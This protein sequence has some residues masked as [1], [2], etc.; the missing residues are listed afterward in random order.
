MNIWKNLKGVHWTAIA[1]TVLAYALHALA[2]DPSLAPES[3][4]LETVATLLGSSGLVTALSS[5]SVTS[6]GASVGALAFV[7]TLAF[8]ASACTPAQT[9]S[10]QKV[11][12]IV[13]GDLEK[14]DTL[15]QIE[16]DVATDL[17]GVA[18]P[19]L[20]TIVD[21]AIAFLIDSGALSIAAQS[22]AEAMHTSIAAARAGHPR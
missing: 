18:G 10:W 6:K 4:I 19:E 3:Q 14:G 1:L 16:D 12:G 21:D 5:P 11:P 9:A 17:V 2:K 8:G 13:A 7:T 15:Q 22:R 20:V